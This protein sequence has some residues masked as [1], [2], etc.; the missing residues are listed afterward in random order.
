MP[1][2]NMY[3]RYK[4]KRERNNRKGRRSYSPWNNK[5][6]GEKGLEFWE[7]EI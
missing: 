6:E 7:T 5:E 3:K 1:D 4:N 2:L